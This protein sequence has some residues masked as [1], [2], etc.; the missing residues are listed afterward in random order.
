[1]EDWVK[2]AADQLIARKSHQELY[3]HALDNDL[4]GFLEMFVGRLQEAVQQFNGYAGLDDSLRLHWTD[5]GVLRIFEKTGEVPV[6]IYFRNQSG[7]SIY[8]VLGVGSVELH[9][10]VD[11]S[12]ALLF[13]Y[14]GEPLSQ[15]KLAQMILEPLFNRV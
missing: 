5:I 14:N 15:E 8:V 2:N 9:Y 7:V 11:D 3:K 6:S 1:M 13:I 12:G 4:P 10:N